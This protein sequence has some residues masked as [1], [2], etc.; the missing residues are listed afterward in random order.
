MR[1]RKPRNR[2]RSSRVDTLTRL[3]CGFICVGLLTIILY[4]LLYV[5]A[6]SVYRRGR[7]S[8][9]GYLLLLNN[10]MVVRGLFNS[11]LY[12][13][14]GTATST[15]LTVFSSFALAQHSLKRRN[16]LETLFF[17]LPFHVSGGMIATYLVVRGLGL[18][19]TMWALILPF[20][21]GY[22]NMTELKKRFEHGVARDLQKAAAIDGC[23]PWRFLGRIALPLLSPTI[24][25]IAFR[26]F[27]GYWGN[28]FYAQLFI[29][30]RTKY[31]LSLIL[32]EL[33]VRNQAA[34][35]L[36]TQASAQGIHA[37]QMAQYALIVLSSLPILF[38][39]LLI[40]RKLH[41][42]KGGVS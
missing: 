3:I 20:A 2:I 14:V 33:L 15:V 36:S 32:N 4:P 30:D 7:F 28:Y 40:Q 24:A 26:Y 39:F 31:P 17:F 10:R 38:V 42:S 41:E 27:V 13:S 11:I 23:G 22:R 18:I 29:T 37:I 16:L 5:L 35:V 25:L 34:D 21:I 1:D 19:N 8:L 12:S 9:D 6:A